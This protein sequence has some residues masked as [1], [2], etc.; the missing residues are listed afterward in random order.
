[1]NPKEIAK[2]YMW[3][4]TEAWQ[5][6]NNNAFDEIED[7]N[8][9]FHYLPEFTDVTGGLDG[10]KQHV[11]DMQKVFSN[12]K[13]SSMK[14]ITGEG[15]VFSFLASGQ[16]T[17]VGQMPGWPPPSGKEISWVQ[18]FVCR[19]KED[20]VSEVWNYLSLKP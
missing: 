3:A 9:V 16:M 15:N 7:Q 8:V 20:K 19:I 14:Y 5:N 11:V 4:Q 18:M 13:V 10:H 12:L 1:M 17:I 2:K 6:G